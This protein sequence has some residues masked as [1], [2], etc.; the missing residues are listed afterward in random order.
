MRRS[1]AEPPGTCSVDDADD[2]GRVLPE[3]RPLGAVTKPPH[4]ANRGLTAQASTSHLALTHDL[5]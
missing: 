4:G 3:R 1:E 2:S 5:S